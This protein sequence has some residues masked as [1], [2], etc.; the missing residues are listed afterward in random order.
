MKWLKEKY[1]DQPE[2]IRFW[3]EIKAG[4]DKFEEDHIPGRFTIWKNGAY[5]FR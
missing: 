4:F 1:Q 3:E 5:K 2:L